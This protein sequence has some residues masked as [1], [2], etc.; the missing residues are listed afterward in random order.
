MLDT[1]SLP[2]SL[3]TLFNQFGETYEAGE[4][5]TFTKGISKIKMRWTC[6]TPMKNLSPF[7]H[8]MVHTAR[9]IINVSAIIPFEP[10]TEPKEIELEFAV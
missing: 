3:L 10:G 8:A 7:T 6:P 9:K 4:I 1:K 2:D 5:T